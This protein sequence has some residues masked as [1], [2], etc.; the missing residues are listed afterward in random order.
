[1]TLPGP[2]T[3]GLSPKTPL[4]DIEINPLEDFT[5]DR[6]LP[7]P[8]HLGRAVLTMAVLGGYL[9]FRRKTHSAPARKIIRNGCTRLTT[10]AQA[11][12]RALPPDKG[13]KLYQRMGSSKICA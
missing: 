12:E 11:C 3:P 10:S 9:N 8:D 2:D 6:K 1:M 7:P 5:K 13:S 4:T